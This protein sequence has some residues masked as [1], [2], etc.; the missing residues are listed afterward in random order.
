M[1]NKHTLLA[2]SA[3]ALLASVTQANAGEFYIAVTGGANFLSSDRSGFIAIPTLSGGTT[4]YSQDSDTGFVLGGAIGVHLDRWLNGLR[5]E[6]EASYRRNDVNGIWSV[7]TFSG[8]DVGVINANES[9]FAVMANI[10]YDINVG[11]KWVPYIGGGVGWA[12]TKA[13]GAF[14]T[15]F[16]DFGGAFSGGGTFDRE[17]S[18]FAWQLGFGLNYPIQDNVRLGLGY[19]YF[20][21]PDIKNN[22]FLGKNNLPVNFDHEDH[23]VQLQLTVDVY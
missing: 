21:G 6:L 2:S 11:Q 20:R 4:T 23:T 14:R 17:E 9:K 3:L 7:S 19:R 12:R 18:G 8:L 22:V 13:D 10:W 16:T 15:T 5:A 1:R